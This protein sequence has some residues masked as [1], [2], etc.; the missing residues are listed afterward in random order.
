[1]ATGPVLFFYDYVDPASYILD[2]A[3]GKGSGGGAEVSWRPLELRP[4]P[5]ARIDAGGEEWQA[6]RRSADAAAR[7]YGVELVHPGF[8]PWSRKAHELALHAR[9]KGCFRGVHDALFRAHFVE[10]RDIGRVD[11]LVELAAASGLERTETKAVLDVDRF[12]DPLRAF[13]AEAERL[14]VRGVPTLLVGEAR[15]EGIHDRETLEDF[16]RLASS[17]PA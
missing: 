3:L 10:G 16:L 5:A 2:A 8:V 14:R 7:H 4:P 12:L 9:D 6:I 13:R 17:P 15:L 1:M 11:V